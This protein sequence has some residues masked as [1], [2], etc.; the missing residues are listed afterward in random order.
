MNIYSRGRE[1]FGDG[2]RDLGFLLATHASLALVAAHTREALA[3]AEDIAAH[4]RQALEGRTVIGQATGIFMAG[5]TAHRRS[6]H[7]R[8]A[9]THR[10]GRPLARD[11]ERPL[12]RGDVSR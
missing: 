6:R 9:L 4:L 1:G 5:R 12:R 11:G 7:R 10:P 3:E 8:P 2:A